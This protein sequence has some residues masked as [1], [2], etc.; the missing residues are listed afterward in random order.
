[1]AEMKTYV[2]LITGKTKR[3]DNPTY[4]QFAGFEPHAGK[5]DEDGNAILN[6]AEQSRVDKAQQAAADIAAQAEKDAAAQAAAAHDS[7]SN[8]A[9]D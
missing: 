5:V 9:G 7:S 1:M 8:P 4:M 2:H 6:K 3:S